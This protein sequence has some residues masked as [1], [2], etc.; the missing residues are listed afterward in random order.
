MNTM[1]QDETS[2]RAPT[3]PLAAG[4]RRH[5]P[6]QLEFLVLTLPPSTSRAEVR[7]L[8]AEH[9]EYG[10]WELDRV[11]V[12]SGGGRKIWLRRRIQRVERTW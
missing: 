12:W 8:L 6:T 5:G 10:R 4:A 1:E 7:A 2:R 9:A 3:R 11:R